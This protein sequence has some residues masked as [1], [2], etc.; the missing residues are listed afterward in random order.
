MLLLRGRRFGGFYVLS[1]V[2]VV[3]MEQVRTCTSVFNA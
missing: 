2:I 1:D 3:F